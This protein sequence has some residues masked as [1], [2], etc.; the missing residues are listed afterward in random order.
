MPDRNTLSHAALNDIYSVIYKN[1][2]TVIS[3]SLPKVVPISFDFWNGNI[4]RMA[5]ISYWAT[6]IDS[7]YVIRK[8]C[9]QTANFPHPHTHDVI[10]KSF[11]SLKSKYGIENRKFLPCTDNGSNL[12]KACKALKLPRELY[13]AH[14]IHLLVSVDL[15]KNSAMEMVQDLISKLKRIMKSLMYKYQQLKQIHDQEFNKPLHCFTIN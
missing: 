13:L 4:K 12:I 11:Q 5:Y 7:E 14:N 1:I 15:L 6:W 10:A 8:V 3:A 9:L 2:H